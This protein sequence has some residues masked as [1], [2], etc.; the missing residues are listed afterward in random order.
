MLK[1]LLYDL[2]EG[3]LRISNAEQTVVLV[4]G[5]RSRL[6]RFANS[7]VHQNT[8]VRN[9]SISV[10]VRFGN[11][12][13][14]AE[15]NAINS[16]EDIASLVR[17]AEEMA[18]ISPE[19]PE[20]LEVPKSGKLETSPDTF[21]ELTA[22]ADPSHLIDMATRLIK[23]TPKPFEAF[24]TISGGADEMVVLTSEGFEGYRGVTAAHV[25][26]NPI[27]DLTHGYLVQK[28]GH[29]FRDFDVELI[30]QRAQD[31][32]SFVLN[33]AEPQPG[34]WTVILEPLAV[35]ELLGFLN[36]MGLSARSVLDGIS[37]LGE[38]LGK[39]IFSER[40]TLYDDPLNPR[41]YPFPFDAEGRKKGLTTVVERGVLKNLAHDS[42]TA[43][44]L[45]TKSNACATTLQASRPMFLNLRLKE[46]DE[47]YGEIL[48][49]S[50][51]AL[52]V[53]RFWYTNI[54]NP[55]DLSITGMTRDGLFLVE[56][57][58]IVG[59]VKNMRFNVSLFDVFSNVVSVSKESEPVG[60]STWYGPFIAIGAIVPTLKVE[61][62]NFSSSTLF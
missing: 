50:E 29:T 2:A 42:I 6:V 32:L 3:V 38:K 49:G 25:K 36:W 34:K 37:P 47:G 53:T 35:A 16:P 11:R 15:S 43:K 39:G 30:L 46:G 58:R 33:P 61:G 57:G 55:R 28:S 23:G 52:L 59:S 27:H 17:K 48:N 60:D 9:V 4:K 41:G 18:K 7:R 51:R 1:Q 5:E 10:H 44:R 13:A 40:F 62:F 21:D 24:G 54:V 12:A 45:G 14:T 56:D 20:L 19:N 26:Y 31:R 22:E 8:E